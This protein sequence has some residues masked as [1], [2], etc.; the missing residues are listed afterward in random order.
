MSVDSSERARLIAKKYEQLV[1]ESSIVECPVCKVNIDIEFYK[2][3]GCCNT[4]LSDIEAKQ[5]SPVLEGITCK[6]CGKA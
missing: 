4:D 2:V 3:C 5:P 6:Y 1:D